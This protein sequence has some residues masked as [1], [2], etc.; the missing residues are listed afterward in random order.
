M[1]L[2]KTLLCYFQLNEVFVDTKNTP[3]V[4]KRVQ[5]IDKQGEFESRRSV[6]NF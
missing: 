1:L 3:I 2:I 5:P 4:K 6:F